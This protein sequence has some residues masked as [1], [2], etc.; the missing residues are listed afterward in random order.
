[1]ENLNI[2]CDNSADGS[3]LKLTHAELLDLCLVCRVVV[4]K[5]IHLSTLEKRLDPMLEPRRQMTLVTMENNKFMVQLY[6]KGDLVKILD[7]SP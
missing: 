4:N 5:P 2:N 6:Q 7:G 1:M 3:M